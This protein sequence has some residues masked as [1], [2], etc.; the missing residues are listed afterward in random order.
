MPKEYFN[1][2]L[3]K[4]SFRNE[5]LS[6]A[7]FSGS[8]LRGADLSGSNLMGA[9]L[10]NVRTGITPMNV[11]L[12]FIFALAVSLLSGYVAAEVGHIIRQMLIDTQQKVRVAGIITIVLLVLF[13]IYFLWK[14]GNNAIRNLIIPTIIAAIAMGVIAKISGLGTGKGMLYLVFAT[15]MAT[16]MVYVGTISRAAA[17]SLSN[18]LFTIVALAGGM[19]GKSIAGGIGPVIFAVFCALISKKALSG[20]KGFDALR[21]VAFYV[22]TKFGTSFRHANLTNADFSHSRIHNADFTGAAIANVNWG[23]AKRI[24]CKIDDAIITDKKKKQNG[25]REK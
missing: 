16:V 10:T 12:I 14:G 15:I 24:N 9:S 5:D 22:T 4:L 11:V 2:N 8:D 20:A 23:D 7:S 19:F 6:S 1:K 17:G 18:I 3:Q 25:G 21:K 13:L